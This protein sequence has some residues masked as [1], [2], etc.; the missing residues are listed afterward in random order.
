MIAPLRMAFQALFANPLRS[1][2]TMLGN[3]IGVMCVVALVNIGISG[4]A[5][6]Q[7]NLSSIGQNTIFVFPRFDPDGETSKDRWRPLKLE[8]VDAVKNG[9]PS[10][11]AVSPHQEVTARVSFG[12]SHMG[13]QIAGSWPTMLTIRDWR[14]E[15]G[16][17]FTEADV[18]ASSKVCLIGRTVLNEL[19]GN[20]DP[21]GQTVRINQ[22][23][24]QV[25]GTLA[26]KGTF[27]T[28]QDQD[29]LIITPI[30]ALQERLRG[31]RDIQLIYAAAVSR[32]EMDKA[33]EE[34]RAAIRQR[35]QLPPD[36]KDTIDT[37]DMGEL[38]A[39]VDK[40]LFAATALLAAIAFISL[41]VGGIGI[42]NI[43]LVSVTERTREIGLRM[44]V[45]AT[46]LDVLLQFLV[47]AMVM[48]IVGGSMGALLGV[49]LSAG[50]SL[51]L[52]WPLSISAMSLAVAL[53]FSAAVGIFFGLY[54]AL[55]AS[56]LD[57]IVALRH[58]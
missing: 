16:V 52:G 42:M 34:I 41:L 1:A 44:A 20:L 4:R 56:R 39:L 55:R 49:G 53:I 23:P 21:I 47:E 26:P 31:N 35:Q 24:F 2:L 22:H 28:G 13:C 14:I 3:I 45:G 43:M 9:C 51:A 48:S 36:R 6:I 54:P 27:L 46:D 38:T 11:A 50:I 15:S 30:S 5:E 29:R 33:K 25:I 10:V 58:E 8:D 17:A 37:K 40:V 57:P 7:E 19:F 32:E 18:R 12:N